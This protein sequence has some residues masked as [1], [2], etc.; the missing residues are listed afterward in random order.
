[1]MDK[2]N[3]KFAEM[4]NFVKEY[5]NM[6]DE[7]RTLFINNEVERFS[8][9]SEDEKNSEYGRLF[10]K[11]VL[12]RSYIRKIMKINLTSFSSML[13]TAVKYDDIDDVVRNVNNIIEIMEGELDKTDE[14][15]TYQNK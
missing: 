11:S 15:L 12:G 7:K 6:S 3:V 13:R 10:I 9:L 5:D 1:M 2:K 8:S 4:D 14:R